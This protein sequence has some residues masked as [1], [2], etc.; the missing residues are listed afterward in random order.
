MQKNKWIM[1]MMMAASASLAVQSSQA[2]LIL[3]TGNGALVGNDLTDL[4]NN[5]VEGSY[6]PP[7]NLGGFDA[8]FFASNEAAFGGGEAAFNVFDNLT[9]GGD[10]KWC[11][12][13]LPFPQIVG[14]N[15][16]T[17][18]GPIVLSAFTLTSSNDTPTRDPRVWT[19]E[20]SNDTTTGLD[21]TWSAIFSRNIAGSADWTA[22][23]QVIRYSP[24]DGDVFLTNNAFT[25][26]RLRTNAT[27]ATSGA[28]FALAEI[29][30]FGAAPQ[31]VPEPASLGLLAVAGLAL[32]RRRSRA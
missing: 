4:G 26:F 17:T 2:S 7:G 23:D 28:F 11:C 3:G 27:G 6:A 22:R 31:S 24:L 19:L 25:A 30:L 16:S 18:H 8:V 14:A 13:V 29:E 9:G 10:N 1:A 21:G 5:G 20:G 32:A 15:F 12:G